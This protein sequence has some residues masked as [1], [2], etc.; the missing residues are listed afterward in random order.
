MV[1]THQDNMSHYSSNNNNN[2]VLDLDDV[3]TPAR[4][5]ALFSI[6]LLFLNFELCETVA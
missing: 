3:Q 2:S 1:A 6:F 5:I 4:Y